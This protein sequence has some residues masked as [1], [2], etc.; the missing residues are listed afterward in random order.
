MCSQDLWVWQAFFGVPGAT[1]DIVVFNQSSLVEDFIS[2]TAARAGF[3]ANGNYY[4]HGYYLCDGIY[5]EYSFV[6]KTFRDSDDDK[7]RYFKKVQESSRK[8]IERCFGVLQQ[9]W[10]FLKNPCRM[11]HRE[12][13]STVMYACIIMHNMILED[14]GRA[15]CPDHSPDDIEQFTPATMDERVKNHGIMRSQEL[16]NNLKADLVEAAW[17][18]KPIRVDNDGPSD[19]DEDEDE[20]DDEADEDEA[21][22][23]HED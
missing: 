16:H 19:E 11:W 22:D 5:P 7:R 12:K 1:N 20:N 18:L 21:D 3:Y 23:E 17:S 15:I 6:V 14:E 2:G 4:D 13:I 8:D 10:Q 9:R